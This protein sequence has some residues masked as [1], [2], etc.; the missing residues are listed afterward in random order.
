ML[1]ERFENIKNLINE[2]AEGGR[3]EGLDLLNLREMVL[4]V[5]DFIETE[6]LYYRVNTFK[7]YLDLLE[8]EIYNTLQRSYK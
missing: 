4:D 6:E 2:L 3:I 5:E 8:E 1:I 7:S